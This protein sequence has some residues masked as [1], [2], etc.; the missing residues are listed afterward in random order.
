MEKYTMT[1]DNDIMARAKAL[2]EEKASYKP[3][4]VI[5]AEP[6]TLHDIILYDARG[7][8]AHTYKQ[9][10]ISGESVR[11]ETEYIYNKPPGWI[12]YFADKREKLISLP[13]LYAV[14]ERLVD[15]KHPALARLAKDIASLLCTSTRINYGAD[16]ITHNYGASTAETL[17]RPLPDSDTMKNLKGKKTGRNALQ[18]LLM[19][20]DV[21]KAEETL[22]KVRN[23]RP[24]LWTINKESR[25]ADSE[26]AVLVCAL[27]FKLILDCCDYLN[28]LGRARSVVAEV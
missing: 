28:Y 4:P 10:I 26:R 1:S 27:P 18:A 2:R 17:R 20:Q 3:E 13:L 12:A 8:P 19:A 21:D 6:I 24:Y 15:E 9:V 7:K 22:Q 25:G 16:T 23:V 14:L 11:T 5:S